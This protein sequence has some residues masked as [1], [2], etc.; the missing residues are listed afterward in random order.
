MA[1]FTQLLNAAN[2]GEAGAADRL[3]REVYDELRRLAANRLEQLPPGQTLQPTALVH[4]AYLRLFGGP[5]QWQNRSHFFGAAANAIRNILVERARRVGAIRRGGG[6]K[7][8]PLDSVQLE[9]TPDN[10]A[11]VLAVHEA[12]V[13]LDAADP[14]KGR[15]VAL[16]FFAGLTIDQV[17]ETLGLSTATVEREWSFARAWLHR[18]LDRNQ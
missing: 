1:D 14:R 4:E 12:L 15:I 18:E 3:L 11:N 13:R 8:L 7:K 5:T 6:R 2:N 9:G 17:A 16:R 10:S